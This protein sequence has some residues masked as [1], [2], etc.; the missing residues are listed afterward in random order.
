MNTRKFRP[1]ERVRKSEPVVIGCAA[2]LLR[3]KGFDILLE[4]MRLV[5]KENQNIK[6]RIVGSIDE[7]NPSSY[8][9]SEVVRWSQMENVEILGWQNDMV[10]F[11]QHVML[12]SCYQ[13]V[14]AF[15]KP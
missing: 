11:W 13:C 6:L 15:R 1:L 10:G 12:R 14:K 4:A 9:Q 7:S 3:D 2:R 5:G 8:A